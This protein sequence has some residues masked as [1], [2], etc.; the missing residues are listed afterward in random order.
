MSGPSVARTIVPPSR[1]FGRPLPGREARWPSKLPADVLDYTL[2]ISDFL[3]DAADD[4]VVSV[5][6]VPLAVQAGDV[7]VTNLAIEGALLTHWLAGGQQRVDYTIEVSVATLAGRT[8]TVAC[9]IYSGTG[10]P[11]PAPIQPVPV[12]WT[13][14]SP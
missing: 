3:A 4:P 7:A 13:R 14:P 8:L 2:D 11:M 9:M 1:A 6:A 12:S 10:L 5:T